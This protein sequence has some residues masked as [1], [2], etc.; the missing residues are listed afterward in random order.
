[1]VEYGLSVESSFSRFQVIHACVSITAASSQGGQDKVD[2]GSG[3]L[4][5]TRR[6]NKRTATGRLELCD[7]IPFPFPFLVATTSLLS[8]KVVL[9]YARLSRVGMVSASR[10]SDSAFAGC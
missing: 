7:Y 9:L 3:P 2:T 8:L 1:M 6:W 5:P 10:N 4:K